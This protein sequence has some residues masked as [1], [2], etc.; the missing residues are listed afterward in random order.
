MLLYVWGDLMYDVRCMVYDVKCG[1]AMLLIN[2]RHKGAGSRFTGKGKER[3]KSL[4][5]G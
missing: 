1:C 4:T 5:C 3:A 2:A